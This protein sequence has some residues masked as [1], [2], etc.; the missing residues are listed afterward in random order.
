MKH[1]IKVASDTTVA[2][3]RKVSDAASDALESVDSVTGTSM[4]GQGAVEMARK[5][6]AAMAAGRRGLS[7]AVGMGRDEHDVQV[8][9]RAMDSAEIENEE[10]DEESRTMEEMEEERQKVTAVQPEDEHGVQLIV[11]QVSE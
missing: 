9:R 10:D 7:M 4:M 3:H 5:S 11:H 2:I 1:H 8:V 6:R